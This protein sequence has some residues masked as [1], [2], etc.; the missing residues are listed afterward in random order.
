M[1]R[2]FVFLMLLVLGLGGA[3][4]QELTTGAIEGTVVDE[5]GKPIAE[6]LVTVF[7]PQGMNTTST[8]RQGRYSFR[9][10]IP[11][12]YQVRAEAPGYA[13][14][15]QN[16]VQISINRRTQLPFTLNAGMTEEVTVISQA[17]IVDMKSTTTGSTIKIDDFAPYVPMGRNLT[18]VMAVT[19]GVTDG[20]TIGAQNQSISGSSGL[21]N[22]YFVDGVN[23]TNTGFGALGAYSIVY[24]SLGTGVTYDFLEEVQVQ[25]GGFEAEWG[26]AGG[27]VVN[28]VVKS[29]TNTFGFDAAWYEDP[30]SFEG[31]RG[32]RVDNPNMANAVE[33][34]R[35]DIAISAGGPAI[36]DKLFYFAAYNPVIVKQDF[37][38]TSGDAGTAYDLDGNGTADDFFD[39]GETITG[40]RTPET[41]TRERSIDNYAAKL[42]WFMTPNHKFEFTAFGDPSEGEVGPQNPTQFLRNLTDPVGVPDI[43]D[44]A[45]G[46]DYG[47]DQL[48]FKYQGVWTSN[49]FTEILVATKENNF[50]ETGPGTLARS[51]FDVDANT[52]FGG[53]GFYEDKLDETTQFSLKNT[54]VFG[55]VEVRYGIQYDDM[56]FRDP[57]FRSG[58]PYTAYYARLVADVPI[59]TDGD[60]D[61]DSLGIGLL[62]DGSLADSYTALVSSTGAAVDI[63][64][65][66][67][68][69]TRTA[70][71]PL[72]SVTMNEETNF[73]AQV[74]WDVMPNLTVKLGARYTSQELTGSGEFTLPIAT[75]TDDHIVTGEGSTD[76]VPKTYKF[77][78]E[79]APRIGVAW[80]VMNDGKHKVYAN[81]GEYY[82]RVPSD[83]AVRQFSNEVGIEGEWFEDAGLTDPILGPTT[84]VI[85]ANGDGIFETDVD[86]HR[87]QGT[88]AEPG[89]I[90][91]GTID[92]AGDPDEGV[93]PA[94]KLPFTK[95]WL[96]GYAWEV[97]DYTGFEMR[98]IN[99]E[100]GRVLEDVQFASNEQ[101]WNEFY[102]GLLFDNYDGEVFSGHG[103]GS[104]GA[105]VLA[106]PGDNVNANLFPPPVRDYEAM[107]FI[108]NRRFNDGWMAYANYRFSKLDG[109]YE[110]SFR[111]D[112][113]QSDPFITSLFDIP[114]AS[115]NDGTFIES[116]TLKGQYLYGPLNTNRTHVLNAF[117][118]KQFDFG[119]NVGGRVTFMT[120]QP[121][122]PLFAHPTYRN[123]GEIPGANPEYWYLVA[124]DGSSEGGGY[125]VYTDP[126]AFLGDDDIPDMDYDGDGIVDEALGIGSG[127]RLWDYDAVERDYFGENP[128]T[129]TVDLHVGYDWELRDG[130]SR[131][132]FLLDIFNL[133]NDNGALTFDNNYET[134]PGVPNVDYLKA[135]LF[136]GPRNVR[137]G[138][139]FSY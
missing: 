45:T 66:E 93:N 94:T 14:M 6:A 86:C 68:N 62:G 4:A 130:K 98:Y 88:G 10:L 115:A 126:S 60:G 22:A 97:N 95:E 8:D 50:S 92:P 28:T 124:V 56:E 69:V 29:G 3:W 127:P 90:L 133:F 99:R 82:Q 136:Q 116:D 76:Y 25:T 75:I 120:G 81:Y 137:L 117:V 128:A 37:K 31:S 135:N 64:D 43:A 53:A 19:P 61:S 27:G 59:D 84:C 42:A 112:N 71:E 20:G 102:G 55:P 118:S 109:N 125:A 65:G 79:I 131:L 74:A 80:D 34:S 107:E 17:P 114:A 110:G 85:D 13:A 9:G 77:D 49:F 48:S 1:R 5:T 51:F 83:L 38:L 138:L 106:N 39:V 7:G 36:K 52:T 24:G 104:F 33:S 111:N 11:G 119:L 46:L 57:S 26:Q 58:D 32:D 100:L 139:R 70:F 15:I 35:T 129:M 21:E 18:S 132:T 113:G 2:V 134:R 121:R 54:H 105:Y 123:A 101:I 87:V 122:F 47:G 91:D 108:L 96:L 72:D 73:F 12:E 89:V 23:V 67:Y 40:G 30:T 63:E 16:E 103:L 41:V 44:G 78:S